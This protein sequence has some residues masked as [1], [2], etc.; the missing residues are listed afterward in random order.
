MFQYTPEIM[1][2]KTSRI[3][4]VNTFTSSLLSVVNGI[5]KTTSVVKSVL[6]GLDTMVT[7]INSGASITL[8]ASNALC[9]FT[10]KIK[11]I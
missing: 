7:K 2:R 1:R 8:R 3:R 4:G 11:I 9:H 5:S 6:Q 10:N